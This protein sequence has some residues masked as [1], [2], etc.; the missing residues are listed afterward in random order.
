MLQNERCREEKSDVDH[1]P[2]PHLEKSAVDGRSS[3]K[4]KLTTLGKL[5]YGGVRDDASTEAGFRK[6]V[7]GLSLA[8]KVECSSNFSSPGGTRSRETHSSEKVPFALI[9]VTSFATWQ[10]CFIAKSNKYAGAAFYTH[11]TVRRKKVERKA[12]GCAVVGRLEL[13]SRR[14]VEEIAASG[15]KDLGA[16]KL[17]QRPRRTGLEGLL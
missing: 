10:D 8:G 16:R 11:V 3:R 1:C 9:Q 4:E 5:Q 12:I 17:H 7:T 6:S 15:I 13:F 2:L 14:D